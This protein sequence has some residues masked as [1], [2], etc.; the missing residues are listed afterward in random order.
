MPSILEISQLGASVIRTNAKEIRDIHAPEIQTL[1]DAM[2]AT[3]Q[4]AK[5]AGIAAP[6]VG[7]SLCVLIMASSPN[8]RY[9]NAPLMEPTALINPRILAFSE[10]KEKDWEGCL[11]IPG[12]RARVPRHAHVEV[13]YVDRKG[14]AQHAFFDGFLARL[15]QHE[16]D[17]LIGKVFID[18]VDSTEDIITEKEY[19][20]LLNM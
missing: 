16:F 18:R 11:S 8:K 4:E 2:I 17:H 13:A 15:F 9:P 7:H 3:C 10:E 5:G 1:I 12:I 6:Q 19:Q 14:K 20:R